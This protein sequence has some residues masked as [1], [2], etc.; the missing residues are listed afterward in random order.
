ML[1]TYST[2]TESSLIDSCDQCTMLCMSW[3][4]CWTCEIKPK[5]HKFIYEWSLFF[6]L[7]KSDLFLL[8]KKKKKDFDLS[9]YQICFVYVEKTGFW[10]LKKIRYDLLHKIKSFGLK[11]IRSV[12]EELKKCFL[13][14]EKSDMFLWWN[15]KGFWQ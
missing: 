11:N 10:R 1:D 5:S 3:M 12:F 2:Q 9:K 7:K 8:V 15:K 6:C 13:I 4:I 14:T